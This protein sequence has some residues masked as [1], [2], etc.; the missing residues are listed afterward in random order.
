M[1]QQAEL[2]TERGAR[3]TD[4]ALRALRTSAIENRARELVQE[5]RQAAFSERR[6]FVMTLDPPRP[7]LILDAELDR[8]K[9]FSAE[10]ME[11]A[12]AKVTP[13]LDAEIEQRLNSQARLGRR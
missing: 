13:L 3:Q 4:I 1:V 9:P 6:R 12:R 10:E 11:A 8:T 5:A 7:H 2:D